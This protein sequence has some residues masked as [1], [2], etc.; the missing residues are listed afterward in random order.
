MILD[1]SYIWWGFKLEH[2]PLN[3]FEKK[4][5][6]LKLLLAQIHAT[7]R[8]PKGIFFGQLLNC[9]NIDIEKKG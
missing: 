8:L 6:I 5:I 7:N 2:H 4:K 1:G 3:I 9:Y